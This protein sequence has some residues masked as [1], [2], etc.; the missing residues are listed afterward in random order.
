[1]PDNKAASWLILSHAFN[2]DGR[3]ASQTITDKI[4]HLIKL[5][6][7]PIIVSGMLGRKDEVLE[8]HQALSALPVGLR[9]DLRHYLKN[10]I[11]NRLVY[12]LVITCATLMLL[13]FYL[14]E[15]LIIPIETTWSWSI[16][17]FLIGRR[18]IKKQRPTLVYSTGGAYAAHLAGYW[19]AKRYGLPWVAEIHDPMIFASQQTTRRRKKFSAWLEK[20]ICTRADIVW[21]FTEKAMLRAKSRHPQLAG[22]G[23]YVI[24]GVDAPDMKKMPYQPAE[25]LV[26][27]HFGSLST[28]RNLQDFLHGLTVFIRRDPM[29]A[30]QIRLHIYGG[31]MDAISIA[32][33]DQ[34]PHPELIQ[35]FGRLENDPV[36]GETGR[37][38][39]LKRMN[40]AD[41]LLLLHGTDA[42]CEEY[43]PSKLF[44][45]L[46]TQ[47][48]ILA[49]VH[50][51]PQLARMLAEFKHWVVDAQ[52]ADEIAEALEALYQRWKRNDLQDNAKISPYTTYSAVQTLHG[53]TQ[54][55]LAAK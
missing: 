37:N 2:M 38:Q 44:E 41:C 7:K 1:M 34:F 48:P 23:H 14:L 33:I 51:N 54:Q 29:R 5:G 49:L 21:W 6:V 40:A 16:S 8:H 4:P 30:R 19:L 24:A 47:R 52:N 43:I 53:W 36:S 55:M 3:A 28:T 10:R 32:A 31:S 20:I 26:I 12:K 9:F 39:V 27:G 15:K 25:H 11:R 22:R 50:N 45:Y 42:F 13:P 46:W 35:N 17:A 18:I